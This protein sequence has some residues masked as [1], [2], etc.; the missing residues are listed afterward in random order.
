MLESLFNSLSVVT[1]VSLFER[2]RYNALDKMVDKLQKDEEALQQM[3][4]LIL[5]P[6]LSAQ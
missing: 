4:S 1:A 5:L 2:R 6:S 3:L